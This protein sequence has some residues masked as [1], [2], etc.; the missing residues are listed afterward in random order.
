MRSNLVVPDDVQILSEDGGLALSP[1]GR[2]LAFVAATVREPPM[3]WVRTL[4][5][6]TPQPL[7]GT[8][9]AAYPFWSADGQTIGYFADGKLKRIPGRGGSVTIICDAPDGRGGSWSADDTI[10]FAPAPFGPLFRVPASGG[11]PAAVTQATGQTSHR[12]PHVL[13]DG[14]HAFYTEALDESPGISLLDLETGTSTRLLDVGSE[15]FYSPPGWL[16]FVRDSVV[17]AQAYDEEA[18]RLTGDARRLTEPVVFNP[19]RCAGA[20]TVSAEG[21][22]LYQSALTRERIAIFDL[23][24]QP[25]GRLGDPAHMASVFV[26]PDGS[27]LAEARRRDDGLLDLWVVDTQ[28]GLGARLAE[29]LASPYLIWSPDSRSLAYT[30]RIAG[31]LR[32]IVQGLDDSP[33]RTLPG[34]GHAMAWSPDGRTIALATQDPVTSQDILLVEA[35]GSGEPTPWMATPAAETALAF[36]PDG[37]WLL[38]NVEQLPGSPSFL[39]KPVGGTGA[40]ITIDALGAFGA[41]WLDDGRIVYLSGLPLRVREVATHSREGGLELGASRELGLSQLPD[42]EWG[43]LTRDGKRFYAVESS[44]GAG[45]QVFTIVQDWRAELGGG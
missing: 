25:L 44:G 27:R 15:G 1:D 24:G 7:A 36:S 14:R 45:T 35:D 40:S 11:V 37:R 41:W 8:T 26:S 43:T 22:L 2:T 21:T 20:F 19:Q 4:D 23:D 29:D 28:R 33:A 9:N 16:V 13:P 38:V 32:T 42:I 39:A 18:G 10:L 6:S 30:R 31:Q 12:L 3:L 34:W 17:M 5:S